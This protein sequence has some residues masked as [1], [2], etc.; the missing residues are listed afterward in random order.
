MIVCS[1]K[2]SRLLV[3]YFYLFNRSIDWAHPVKQQ[4][5]M[6]FCPLSY[7]KGSKKLKAEIGP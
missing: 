7:S 4:F 2:D 6:P 5:I 1:K 3:Y